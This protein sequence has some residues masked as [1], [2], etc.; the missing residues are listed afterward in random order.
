[1]GKTDLTGVRSGRLVAIEPTAQR[2]KDG[3]IIWRCRCDCGKEHYTKA[4]NISGHRILSCGCLPVVLCREIGRNGKARETHG[5]SGTRLYRIW[6]DMKQ[7]CYYKRHNSYRQYGGRG[8]TVC[9]DWRHSFKAFRDWALAH[10]YDDNLSIDRIDN[11]KGYSPDNCRWATSAEQAANRRPFK[12]KKHPE[13]YPKYDIC[14]VVKTSEEWAKEAGI[15]KKH[16]LPDGEGETGEPILSGQPSHEQKLSIKEAP[17]SE[18]PTKLNGYRSNSQPPREA[19]I[20]STA[21][22][23][24]KQ[25]GFLCTL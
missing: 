10:G 18:P 12:R 1:M 11:E 16:F 4:S 25:G 2:S 5:G 13:Y 8:I 15:K 19:G 20:Y 22:R 14:G 21:S 9:R 3:G 6:G 23:S 24:K 7:R 17:I